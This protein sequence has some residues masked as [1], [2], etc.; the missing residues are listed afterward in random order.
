[1]TFI[2]YRIGYWIGVLVMGFGHGK[3]IEPL[4]D[5]LHRKQAGV[6]AKQIRRVAG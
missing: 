2:C 4:P 3:T 5:R 1:M 6:I